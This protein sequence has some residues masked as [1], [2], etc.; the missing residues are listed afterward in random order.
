MSLAIEAR[1]FPTP[2]TY[3]PAMT[4][5]S[6]ACPEWAG[7]SVTVALKSAGGTSGEIPQ[8]GKVY[9]IDIVGF[10][11]QSSATTNYVLQ[12]NGANGAPM[13]WGNAGNLLANVPLTFSTLPSPPTAGMQYY[14]SD[15]QVTTTASCATAAPTS[16]ICTGSGTGAFAKYMNYLSAGANWYCQ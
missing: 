13:S 12:S 6:A 4:L 16:C 11:A 9:P 14:C 10:P 15:C 3:A 8:F 1:A 7:S 5:L 2:G